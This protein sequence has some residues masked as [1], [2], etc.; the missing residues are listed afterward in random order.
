MLTRAFSHERK[1]VRVKAR[2]LGALLGEEKSWGSR[3]GRV[4]RGKREGKQALVEEEPGRVGKFALEYLWAVH[5]LLK[6]LF[7]FAC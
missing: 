6:C 2:G 3:R 4:C 5:C 7:I 1:I